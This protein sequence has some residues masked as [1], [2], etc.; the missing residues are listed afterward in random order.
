MNFL[1]NS[2]IY[3]ILFISI[4]GV[5]FYLILGS[6]FQSSDALSASL[7][8]QEKIELPVSL[9]IPSIDVDANFE[10]VGL[11][12]D[13]AMDV[14]KG[15][16]NVAWFN[17]SSI[18]GEKGSSVVAGHSGLK[19]GKIGIFDNLNKLKKG[20]RLYV[21]DKNGNIVVFIVHELRSYDLKAETK[22]IFISNDGLSHLNLITCSGVWDEKEG[23]H[24]SRLVVFTSRE[25]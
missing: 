13:G 19:D 10:Y 24:S 9:R 1:K 21:V 16:K 22:D 17:A 3:S 7:Q 15:P 4:I 25:I 11:T 20:D 23:T 12:Q 5:I 6:S 2:S 8:K 18:P 14:P